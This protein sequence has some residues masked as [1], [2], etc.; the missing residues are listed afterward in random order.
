MRIPSITV[1]ENQLWFAATT[2][3]E[4][5]DATVPVTRCNPSVDFV[6]NKNL[7]GPSFE[8]RMVRSFSEDCAFLE[9]INDYSYRIKKGFVPN[10]NVIIAMHVVT[11]DVTIDHV[12]LLLLST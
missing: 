5:S 1:I 12:L 7:P 2:I 3:A 11:C 4:F 9:K 8:E 10:M 6:V